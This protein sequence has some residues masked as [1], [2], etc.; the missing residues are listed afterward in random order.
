MAG[1]QRQAIRGEEIGGRGRIAPEQQ[2]ISGDFAVEAGADRKAFF[3]EANGG[4]HQPC[5]GQP[6]MGAMRRFQ[7]GQCA[8]YTNSAPTRHGFKEG[9]GPAITQQKARRCGS[10]RDFPPIP[11]LDPAIGSAAE[12]DEGTTP[13]AG[14]L[15]FHQC[16]HRLHRHRGIKSGTAIP[17]HAKPGFDCQR[18]ASRDHMALRGLSGGGEGGEEEGEEKKETDHGVGLLL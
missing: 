12:H 10:R 9:H 17:Q 13:N 4:F 5:P 6:A 11:G 7:H 1:R 14:G 16:Q 3:S 18:M 15:R 8:R 2:R